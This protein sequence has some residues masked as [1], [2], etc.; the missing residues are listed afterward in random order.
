MTRPQRRAYACHLAAVVCLGLGAWAAAYQPGLAIAGGVGAVVLW[1]V[2]RDYQRDHRD[3]LARHEQA[4]RDAV[5]YPD[6]QRDGP[7][8][9]ASEAAEWALITARIDLDQEQQ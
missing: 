5:M 7:P 8:L 4:R 2:A 6:P 9:T 3:L 1:L